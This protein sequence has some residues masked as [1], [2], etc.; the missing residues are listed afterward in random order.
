MTS[1]NE[2]DPGALRQLEAWLRRDYPT[3]H[4]IFSDG[5]VR[6][7]G[8]HPVLHEVQEIARYS[9]CMALPPDYPNSLPVV[10]ETADRIPRVEDRHVNVTN[11]SLCGVPAALWIALEGNFSVGRVLDIPVRN[12]LIGNC[13]I[14]AG[15]NWPHG[16][17]AHGA[18]G[19]LQFFDET[20]GTDNP[21]TVVKLIDG[22]INEKL[23][24]HWPC[25]CGSGAV[26][27]K[28]HADAIQKL[29]MVPP[30]LLAQSGIL[31]LNL[32]KR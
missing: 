8:T 5:V 20:I 30:E 2:R 13:M 9:L 32:M 28:C 29:R 15:E 26:V 7:R 19:M 1:W 14:E 23:R 10:W 3:M 24:G 12:Y 21:Q 27:R 6:I 4:A 17:W 16:E 25:P 11:G 22:L 31:I 18:K